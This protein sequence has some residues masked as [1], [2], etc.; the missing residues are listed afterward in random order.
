M[1]AFDKVPHLRLLNKLRSYGISNQTCLWIQNFLSDRKQRVQLNG[2]YSKWHKV[3]SGIPQ[4]SVLGP[5]LFVLFIND[6]PLHVKSD[7]YMFADD[8]KLY[9]EIV[10]Q[11]D[12]EMVQ[13][14]INNLFKWSEKWLLRF[15][16]DKCKVVSISGKSQQHR[17]TNYTMLTYSGSY[18]TLESV[19]SEKDI[20]VTID[21]KLNFEKHIQTQVNKA[22]QIVGVIRRS[23]KYLNFKTFC[24]LFKS[25]VRPHL[26]YACSVWNPYKLKDIE[27]I[28]NVQRRAT[29]M[30]PDMKDLTYEERLRKLKLP[31][32]RYRRLRGDMVETYKIVSGIY[33]KRV[34][35]DLL[36]THTSTQHQT[37]GH[38]RKLA[39]NRSRLD[40][41]KHYFTNKVVEDWNSLPDSV[42]TAKNVKIFEN[43][44]DKL[45]KDHPMMYDH[46]YNKNNT[47]T[48]GKRQF[49]PDEEIEPNTEEDS[50]LLR[51]EQP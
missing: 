42:V 19:E 36:P 2:S 26:E 40:I 5:I 1:K 51:L 37:R 48:T 38:S 20:G 35:K 7:V 47:V 14:D 28:E 44:L 3:T 31:S 12:I 21:S 8:T 34:T 22:N 9:R 13:S 23:F 49:N 18:V 41:R 30:L 50:Q 15:H 29:K 46:T 6:L 25:L 11:S 33:D 16:P 10:Y 39:K 4:G 45:W 17:S 32:L 43:R 24:L 27:A